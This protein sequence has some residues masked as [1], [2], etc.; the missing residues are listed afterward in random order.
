MLRST[1]SSRRWVM[2]DTARQTLNGPDNGALYAEGTDAESVNSENNVDFLSNG[3][4]MKCT[5]GNANGSGETYIFAAF[6]ERPFK[7]SNAR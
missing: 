7:Y 1:G 6:A 2:L 5:N 4:K 3:F